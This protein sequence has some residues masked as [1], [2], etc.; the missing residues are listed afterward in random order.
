MEPDHLKGE[1]LHPI[2]GWIPEGDRQ[3]DLPKWHGLLSR[4]N[5]M[6]RRSSGWMRDRL[7]PM[8][9]SIS[10]YM[11][12]RPLPPSI[13]TLVSHFV[14]MI[15]STTS[16]YLPDCGTLSEWSVRSKVTANS[17]HR[18]KEGRPAQPYRPRDMQASGDA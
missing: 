17:D 9:S 6:E 14:P 12:L 2:I 16:E 4:H 1:G 7:M 5:V 10:A 3:I 8:A 11:I 18:R 15:G 13:S